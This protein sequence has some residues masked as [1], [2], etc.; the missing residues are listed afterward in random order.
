MSSNKMNVFTKENLDVYLK[1]LAKEF[2]KLNGTKMPAEIT[3]IGGAAILANYGFRDSTTDIDAVIHASSAMKEAVNHVGDK[4]KL[5]SSWLNADF[6]N[7]ASYSAKLTEI[8]VYYKTFSNILTIR[9]VSAE[10]LIAMKLKAGRK[11][12]NDL[13]DI[14]GIL[15]EHQKRGNPLTLEKINTAVTILYGGFDSIPKD[16]AVFIENAFTCADLEK[17]YNDIINDENLSRDILI[18][19]NKDYPKILKESNT[20][21]ILA[22]LKAKKKNKDLERQ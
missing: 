4:F 5:Q 13:S 12:K 1:E 21:D 17:I 9:T 11:Y 16:S 6:M 19:F 7:T 18:D 8:S 22:S 20:D 14:I 3:L 10:Y 2:R 15:A